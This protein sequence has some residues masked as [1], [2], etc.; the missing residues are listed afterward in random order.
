MFRTAYL[1]LLFKHL[2]T[3]RIVCKGSLPH[4]NCSHYSKIAIIHK[5]EN[6]SSNSFV[7]LEE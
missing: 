1:D 5:E 4:Q 7:S 2:Y 6:D 3:F